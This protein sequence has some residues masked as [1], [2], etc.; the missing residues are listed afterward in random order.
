MRQGGRATAPP[1]FVRVGQP[2]ARRLRSLEISQRSRKGTA[3]PVDLKAPPPPP[4]AVPLLLVFLG[5]HGVMGAA[6]GIA[7]AAV[8]ILLDVGGLRGLL[9]ASPAPALP[10]AMLYFACAL[11]FA[12]AKMAA[13]VMSLPSPPQRRGR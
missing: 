13:A 4:S 3:V 2:G 10:M 12:G 8:M 1:F 7:F 6:I 9:N 11:T 5:L